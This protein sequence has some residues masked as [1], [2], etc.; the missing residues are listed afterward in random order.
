MAPLLVFAGLRVLLKPGKR[1]AIYAGM[2]VIPFLLSQS[3]GGLSICAA[4]IGVA[5]L[6]TFRRQQ[7]KRKILFALVPAA[8]FVGLILI[9]PNPISLRIAQVISGADSSTHS[10]TDNGFIVAYAI[11]ASKSIWWGAGLGQAKLNDVSMLGAGFNIGI[12]PNS[13]AGTF[14]ELGIVAVLVKFVAEIVLFFRTRV[15]GSTFRL[16]MF[17]IAFL[18]QFTGSTL[19]NVQEYVMWGL[20]FGPFFLTLNYLNSNGQR[21]NIA[22]L[23]S[24]AGLQPAPQS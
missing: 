17:V 19:M 8:I 16:A 2:I 13:V 4:G 23:P 9:I 5:L 7:S 3:F 15:Y 14:A 24:V 10:R 21:V 20:A 22:R 6:V 11:A 18:Y 12:I 1:N